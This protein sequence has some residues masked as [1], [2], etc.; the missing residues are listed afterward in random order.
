MKKIYYHILEYSDYGNIG[1][2][3]YYLTMKEA[4][5]RVW[6][7]QDMFP[8]SHFQIESSGSKKEPNNTTV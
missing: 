2:Q 7:L 6:D 5:K 4:E 1:H 8:N 3:G